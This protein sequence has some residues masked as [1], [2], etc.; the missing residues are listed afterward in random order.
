MVTRVGII[1]TGIMGADHAQIL[2]RFVSGAELALVADVDLDRAERVASQLGCGATSDP[3]A[4]IDDADVDAV[5]VASHDSTHA[6][7]VLGSVQAEKPVLCEKPLAP[8][9][10]EAAGLIRSVGDGAALVSLGFMRRF[11]PGYAALKEQ[12]R[13]GS[14][15]RPL[16]VHS[17]GRGVSTGPGWTDELSVTS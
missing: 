3:L 13:D 5:L 11:D 7:F 8:T 17:V 15:G 12:I 16:R 1:G 9:L 4:L 6:A 14:I 2:H 10:P